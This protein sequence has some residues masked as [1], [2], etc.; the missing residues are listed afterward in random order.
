MRRSVALLVALSV[1]GLGCGGTTSSNH[2]DLGVGD[3]A[4]VDDGG[5]SAATAC[6][7]EATAYCNLQATCN[8]T[9]PATR[10]NGDC[11]ARRTTLCINALGAPG[12]GSTV[13]AVVACGQAYVGYDCANFSNGVPP[14]A[15]APPAGTLTN[16]T[17]C[18]F[19]AQCQSAFCAVAPDAN[20]GVCAPSTNMGDPCVSG[21][22]A[23]GLY[24]SRVSQTCKLHGAV[25]DD[26]DSD[27]T[28]GYRLS[29]VDSTQTEEGTC[30]PTVATAGLP[31]LQARPSPSASP[32]PSQANCDI[33]QGL[34]CVG[35]TVAARVCVLTTYA[36]PAP[37]GS[38][39]PCGS[40]PSPTPAT[41]ALCTGGTQCIYSDT[42]LQSGTCAAAAGDGQ[43]CSTVI[44]VAHATYA[45]CLAPSK[46]V[47]ADVDGGINGMSNGG[48]TGVCDFPGASYCQ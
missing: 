22:C 20:C 4:V 32:L 39:T 29:C 42:K 23:A 6:A 15:C 24:C 44:D 14:A 30:L 45:A 9:I 28:C 18:N 5:Q 2:Q 35:T 25:G 3:L 38:P 37:Q 46:C 41:Y 1:A 19:S 21:A 43:S 40:V 13:A 48:M 10:Y 8:Q 11:V 34:Y 16:G 26:C 17:A 47:G 12:T 36:S 7:A 33:T 31:C 27:D